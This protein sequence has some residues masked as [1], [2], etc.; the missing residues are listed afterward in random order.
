MEKIKLIVDALDSVN[1]FDIV[2]YDMK[3][4][5]P[6]FDYVVIASSTSE[7]QLQA[8]ISHITKGLVEAKY[9]APRVEGKNSNAWVLIDCGDIIVNVFTK[10]EREHYNLEKMLAE[11][12][13]IDLDKLRK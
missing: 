6:F 7:R 1:L 5:S 8:S 2:V 10:D 3:E 11:I 13:N 12:N 9:Q 4:K